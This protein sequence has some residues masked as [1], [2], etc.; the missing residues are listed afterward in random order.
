MILQAKTNPNLVKI[1]ITSDKMFGMG[2]LSGLG[3]EGTFQGD[4]NIE[5]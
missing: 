1:V 5:I 2:L 3:C 4:K